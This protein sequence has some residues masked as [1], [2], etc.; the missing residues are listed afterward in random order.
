[1]FP[2]KATSSKAKDNLQ[3]DINQLERK[4]TNSMSAQEGGVLKRLRDMKEET[5]RFCTDIQDDV[6]RRFKQVDGRGVVLLSEDEQLL[7][8]KKQAESLAQ[9][10]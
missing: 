8:M 1:M 3:H 7:Y 9:V 5:T 2:A 6:E 4:F 10:Q